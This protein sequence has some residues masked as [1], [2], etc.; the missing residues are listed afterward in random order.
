VVG[1]VEV[2]RVAVGAADDDRERFVRLEV[3]PGLSTG[4]T[5]FWPVA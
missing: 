1:V 3:Q 4:A 5:A 2:R